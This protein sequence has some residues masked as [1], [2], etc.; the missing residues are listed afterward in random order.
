M[1]KWSSRFLTCAAIC[2]H[3]LIIINLNRPAGILFDCRIF[4]YDSWR[5]NCNA[6]VKTSTSSSLTVA[7]PWKRSFDKHTS[8]TKHH[9]YHGYR[10]F[11]FL[12]LSK[13]KSCLGR[14]FNVT[15][16]SFTFLWMSGVGSGCGHY[17]SLSGLRLEIISRPGPSVVSDSISRHVRVQGWSVKTPTIS[18]SG[19]GTEMTSSIE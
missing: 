8:L 10:E 1:M 12:P 19:K 16:H 3:I 13:L 11:F 17:R 6:Q 14:N 18:I 4:K 9:S 2:G 5:C 7:S 15:L